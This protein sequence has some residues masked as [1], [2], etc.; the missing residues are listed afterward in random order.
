MNSHTE[1]AACL[2][3]LMSRRQ[4]AAQLG[5]CTRSIDWLISTGKLAHVRIGRRVQIP[6]AQLLEFAATGQT[7]R[8]RPAQD[9]ETN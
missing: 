8:I 3:V 9:E 4:A 2:P 5:L 7:G 1:P 6:T